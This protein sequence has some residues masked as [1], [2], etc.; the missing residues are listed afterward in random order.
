MTPPARE[1]WAQDEFLVIPEF[2]P[3]AAVGALLDDPRRLEPGQNRNCIPR[4]KKGGRA[5][6]PRARAQSEP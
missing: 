5:R 1:C 4:H 3:P 2:L 6:G